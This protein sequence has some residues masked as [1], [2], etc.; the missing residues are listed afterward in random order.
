M[1]LSNA[2]LSYPFDSSPALF[3]ETTEPDYD[4]PC[5]SHNH[6]AVHGPPAPLG[7]WRYQTRRGR[8][9]ASLLAVFFSIGVHAL[10]L[11]G[12]N[13]KRIDRPKYVEP[14][15]AVILLKM[16][17]LPDDPDD[18]IPDVDKGSEAPDGVDVPRLADI[19]STVILDNMMTQAF[20]PRS[21]QPNLNI[22]GTKLTSIPT[23]VRIGA[24]G[25][26]I[27][28]IFN[29]A[30]LDRAPSPVFQPP[31]NIPQTLR[32]AGGEVN[33]VVEFV[34]NNKGEV[35]DAQILS[36]TDRRFDDVATTA[37]MKWRFK[38]GMKRG[39]PVAV[40]IHQPFL[41]TITSER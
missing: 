10:I 38:P 4:H 19:P 9:M 36:T 12:F 23:H 25:K 33:V 15:L 17:E 29:L 34:V 1:R 26:G 2:S 20:D 39:R 41:I 22:T 3:P 37:V 13:T 16:P 11:F 28:E 40:R 7:S 8:K 14:A 27:K 31:P 5:C 32:Q 24:G 6:T 35:V 21:L 30:D 18:E